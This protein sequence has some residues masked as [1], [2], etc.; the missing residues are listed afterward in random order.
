MGDVINIHR[1]RSATDH[2]KAQCFL[3][4]LQ[5]CGKYIA[6]AQLQGI[7]TG[8]ENDGQQLVDLIDKLTLDHGE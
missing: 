4:V 7:Y 5:A 3:K 6:F 1:G 2:E 8:W